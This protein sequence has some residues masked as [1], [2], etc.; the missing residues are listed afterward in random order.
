MVTNLMLA[1]VAAQSERGKPAV[2]PE[3]VIYVAKPSI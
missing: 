3:S 2:A 1:G